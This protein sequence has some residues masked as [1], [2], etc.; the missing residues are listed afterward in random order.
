MNLIVAQIFMSCLAVICW[1]GVAF[2]ALVAY[3]PFE[4]NAVDL[5]NNNNGIVHGQP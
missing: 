1:V 2:G 5:A 4:G 3:Y